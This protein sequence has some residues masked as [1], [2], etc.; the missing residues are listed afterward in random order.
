MLVSASS[1]LLP[2]TNE[3]AGRQRFHRCFSVHR[4]GGGD[5]ADPSLEADLPTEAD[6]LEADSRCGKD[7]NN[8]SKN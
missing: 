8:T 1:N 5:R 2:P 7:P 6:A 4:G 3:V